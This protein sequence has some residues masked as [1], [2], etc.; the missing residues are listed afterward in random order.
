MLCAGW[1]AICSKVGAFCR[2][3]QPWRQV[4]WCAHD[5]GGH[6]RYMCRRRCNCGDSP[7][8]RVCR[9]IGGVVYHWHGTG[10]PG[11]GADLCQAPAL[12]RAGDDF[13]VFGAELRQG[14]RAVYELCYVLR[15]Y[16]QRC[17]QHTAGDRTYSGTHRAD[18]L[19]FSRCA[20][21]FG[22][23]VCFFWRDEDSLPGRH[24]E[25]VGAIRNSLCPG[26]WSLARAIGQPRT[27]GGKA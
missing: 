22:G 15:H 20:A 13:P 12:Y 24:P 25:D 23:A 27:A 21:A 9:V 3:L 6:C 5:S 8:C 7:A 2:G 10:S 18:F 19:C 1:R 14:G 4:S 11:D 17:V 26:V 16:F